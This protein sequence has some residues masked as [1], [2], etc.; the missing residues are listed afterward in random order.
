ML[1]GESSRYL[2]GNPS[3][4]HAGN[5]LLLIAASE[6]DAIERVCT[7]WALWHQGSGSSGRINNPQDAFGINL[8]ATEVACL[9]GTNI[10]LF[11]ILAQGD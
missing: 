10:C 11:G 6:W 1:G 8:E 4:R 7:T 2:L 5:K 9:A 3:G